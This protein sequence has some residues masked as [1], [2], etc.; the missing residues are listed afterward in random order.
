MTTLH[1]PAHLGSRHRTEA[2]IT[3]SGTKWQYRVC[4]RAIGEGAASLGSG[5][6][7]VDSGDPRVVVALTGPGHDDLVRLIEDLGVRLDAWRA[8]SAE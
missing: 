3:L 4:C 8:W 7:F 6:P 2:G 1:L 5:E